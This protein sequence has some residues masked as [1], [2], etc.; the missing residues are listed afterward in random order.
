MNLPDSGIVH[1]P[2][3]NTIALSGDNTAKF[4]QGQ[5]SC[6]VNSVNATQST[7]GAY[8]NIK[9][10]VLCVF[11]LFAYTQKYFM[12]MPNELITS[13]AKTLQKYGQFSRINIDTT[14]VFKHVYGLIGDAAHTF[15]AKHNINLP[16]TYGTI[17][18]TPDFLIM[19]F[20]G[21]VPRWLFLSQNI[22]LVK[23][24]PTAIWEAHDIMMGLPQITSATS[25][26]FTPHM[27]NLKA[28]NAV[29]FTKGC[30]LGQEIIARTEHLGKA[31]RDLHWC[32]IQGAEPIAPNTA[33]FQD[34]TSVGNVINT[35][36]LDDKMTYILAV[37]NLET[38]ISLPM[39]IE[40]NTISGNSWVALR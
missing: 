8:C 26:E 35:A 36:H 20:W 11:H 39:Q 24:Q 4:L 38:D 18:S 3:L 19:H 30:Y 34:S 17:V 21:D 28:F 27:L 32:H 15:A 12:L 31:K 2:H 40:K 1:L 37:L 9:G 16:T 14:P 5:L 10:R 25:A 7:L 33:V 22:A 6:D 29:S 23:D 13:T